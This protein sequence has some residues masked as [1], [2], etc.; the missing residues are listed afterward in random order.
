MLV[1]GKNLNWHEHQANPDNWLKIPEF[2]VMPMDVDFKGFAYPILGP[3]ANDFYWKVPIFESV[4]TVR[5]LARRRFDTL[6]VLQ[7]RLYSA[8]MSD[9]VM[10][11]P[12]DERPIGWSAE[13][14]FAWRYDAFFSHIIRAISSF[15]HKKQEAMGQLA[16]AMCYALELSSDMPLSASSVKAIRSEMAKAGAAGRIANDP[17]QSDK[18]SVKE[19]WELWQQD[20]SRYKGP[21]AF[22]RD[23]RAKFENLES[24]EVI[25]RWCREWKAATQPAQ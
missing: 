2:N 5:A 8:V 3:K 7:E 12:F 16:Y 20:S 10:F 24:E 11:G 15:Q 17:K 22:A 25:R 4:C 14:I 6:A 1:N 18:A 9:E 23:M 19:C 21:T 13:Q